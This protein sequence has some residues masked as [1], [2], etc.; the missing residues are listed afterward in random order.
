M[1]QAHVKI[2]CTVTIEGELTDYQVLEENPP[3]QG[4]GADVLKMSS[5]FRMKPTLRNGQP[6]EGKVTIPVTLKLAP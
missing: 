5:K 3:G 2:G 4:F 6:V 1:P